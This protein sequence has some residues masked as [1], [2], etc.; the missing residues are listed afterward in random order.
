VLGLGCVAVDDLLFVRE[1]PRADSKMQVLR[2]ERHSGGLTATALVAAGRLG[3]KTAYAGAL[4]DDT[5]SRF[6]RE[7]LAREGV[8]MSHTVRRPAVRP[9]RSV[10]IVEERTGSRTI[11]Y[12]VTGALGADPKRPP[13]E[14]IL[15][16]RVL[17]ADRWGLPGMIRAATLARRAGIPVVAD[18][19]T[20]RLPRFDE[21]LALSDHLIVSEHFARHYTGAR[22]AA[23][24]V[25]RL[26]RD[27]R[28]VV[29]VTCGA[30][31]CWWRDR[32]RREPAHLPAFAVR[33][34]D[35]TGCG[36]VFHGAYAAALA[37]GLPVGDR[38][39]I[40]SVTAALKATQ[41]G[42]QAGIPDWPAV[43]RFLLQRR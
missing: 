6:V 34:V 5:E 2:R 8:D 4:G 15:G 7:I 24:S 40:A 20:F 17:L 1:F 14:V 31:G 9:V 19:E 16:T 22:T 21:L 41:P 18:L 36:D 26:W 3:A 12:D 42:G 11:L 38:L 30:D 37:R 43:Q 10:I 29:V 23:A 13:R 33:A 32:V 28:C 35:T 27:D 39:R 25:N